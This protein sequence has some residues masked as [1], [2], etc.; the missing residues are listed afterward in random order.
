M[1]P[2]RVAPPELRGLLLDT[3][4]VAVHA[5]EIPA[6]VKLPLLSAQAD[7]AV[8]S[9]GIVIVI[10]FHFHSPFVQR[11]HY[12]VDRGNGADARFRKKRMLAG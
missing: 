2:L 3:A 9:V 6:A 11:F 7:A 4:G 12:A 8:R 5:Y 1:P 10:V